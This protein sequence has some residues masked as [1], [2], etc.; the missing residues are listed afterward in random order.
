V[1]RLEKSDEDRAIINTILTLGQ[2]LGMEVIA[3]GVE[4]ATQV[5]MLRQEGCDYGQGYFFA[6]PLPAQSAQELIQQ[7][8][9]LAVS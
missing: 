5:A 9:P 8:Q 3:E 7:Y 4:T 2:K 6:K 1:G